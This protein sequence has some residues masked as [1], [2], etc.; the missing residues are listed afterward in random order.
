[1]TKKKAE[2][3]L[4]I[5]YGSKRVG[6]AFADELG[7]AL[8]I[9]A[10]KPLSTQDLLQ[11]LEVIIK[12]RGVGTCIIGYPLNRDGTATA[13]AKE[14]DLFIAKLENQIKLPVHR[15]DEQLSSVQAAEDMKSMGLSKP[16]NSIKAHQKYRQ[17][18]DLDSRAAALILQ[19]FLEKLDK[20]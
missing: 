4:G 6:L 13:K 2:H 3:Y 10:L 8:P 14:I 1:M 18:G 17:T 16:K 11:K 12:E 15:V 9:P 7:V 19:D 5:D 20:K